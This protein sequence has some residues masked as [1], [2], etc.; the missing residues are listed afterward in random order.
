MTVEKFIRQ[1][2]EAFEKSLSDKV[3]KS[4]PALPVVTIS[5]EPGSGGSLIAENVAQRLGYRLYS[6]NLL[7]AM[8]HKADVKQQVLEAIEKGRPTLFEDFVSSILPK[9][10]YV[11]K[12]DYFEQLKD[13]ISHLAMIGKAVI[14]GRGANFIIPLEKRF[15]IRVVAPLEVRIK[16]IA[17][18]FK[19]TLEA[20]EKRIANREAKRKAF[21]RDNFRK[22]IGDHMHYDL[23][24]NTER[25]DLETC[26]ELVIG[27]IKGAQVNR[28]FEK[29]SSYILRSKR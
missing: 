6:K 13:T 28:V 8:A 15:S 3:K 22:N 20:A 9:D 10:D 27:A 1:Q 4:Q 12:G 29:T 5:M 21:I 23:T 17:F 26:T 16:N 11:Y 14:V 19:V 7:T 2:S 18:Y 25:M 24:V